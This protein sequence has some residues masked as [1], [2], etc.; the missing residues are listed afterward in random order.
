MKQDASGPAGTIDGLEIR[1]AGEPAR[2]AVVSVGSEL[3][4]GDLVDTNAAWVSSKLRDMGVEVVHHV[5]V[6]DDT[7]EFVEVL[8]WLAE[9]VH[10]IV[11]GGGL[12]PTSD[13]RTRAA[14]AAAA[15]VALEHHDDL[16]EAILQR[17][18]S[19][20]RRMP[21]QNAKQAG[22]PRGAR[23]F[24]PVGTAPGFALTL[25]SPKPTRVY[26]L[27]GVPWELQQ[28]FHRDVAPELQALAGARATVTRVV[29]VIGMGESDVAQVVEPIAGDRD[30]VTLSYLARSHEIQV[31]LTVSA[32]DVGAARGASQPLLD[33]VIDALGG[34]VA[35]LDDEQL[36]DVVLRLLGD[37][38]ETVA[39][40]ESA[41]AGDIAARLGAVPGA[42]H[43]LVGGM[44]V[45][46]TE[47]KH[48][49]LGVD[50]E[51]LDEHGPVSEAVTRAIA[52]LARERFGADWGIGVTGCAGPTEQNGQPVGTAFWALAHPDGHVEVHGRQIPGDRGQI[53]KRLGSAGLD[54]LR[55]RL[56]ER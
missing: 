3:L 56:Q 48:D 55:R 5:A 47:I 30:G 24:P 7:E 35:G 29:H 51:L 37:R 4:L 19:M 2:A 10:V 31:R 13:D 42:S 32:D 52:Q 50:R 20:G 26:A 39:T 9:R 6:R 23:P 1:P 18:A 53:I 45:Y 22:I 49:V 17:F 16:E 36:E 8:A 11:C 21:P 14:I 46:D 12:G 15:G 44:V 43:G 28:L 25:A 40:A 54:L 34:A 27:P 41:T 33:E 38:G